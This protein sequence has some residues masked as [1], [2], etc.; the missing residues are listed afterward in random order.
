MDAK[1][2]WDHGLTF[3]GTADTGFQVSLGA[4]PSVG[5]DNDGF[6]PMELMALSLAGCT[7]MD[8]ISI[9]LKKRQQVTKFEVLV[10][11]DRASEHPRVFTKMNIDYFIT[12]TD[13]NP[14]AVDRAIELSVD[15][16]CPA[17]AMLRNSVE[18]IHSHHIQ[19]AE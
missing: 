7:A 4:D 16:Y 13:I 8:V 2:V 15:K 9:L 3:T 1:V 12:G 19:D 10:R 17:Q 14:A 18:L 11:A 6:R 5:G